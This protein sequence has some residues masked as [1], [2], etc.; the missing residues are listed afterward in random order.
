MGGAAPDP[1]SK[2]GKKPLDANINLVPYIDML[3][4]STLFQVG[5]RIRL[6]VASANFPRYSRNPNTGEQAERAT[7]LVPA[8]QTVYHEAA[9][10]SHLLLPVIP[11]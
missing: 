4:T 2:G 1:T 7:R 8:L 5:H 9:Y 3:M 11:R 6:E 10:P